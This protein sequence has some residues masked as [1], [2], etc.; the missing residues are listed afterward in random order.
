MTLRVRDN[1]GVFG[2]VF[3]GRVRRHVAG[4]V[5]WWVGGLGYY[6]RRSM[7]GRRPAVKGTGKDTANIRANSQVL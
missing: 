3:P 4:H 1:G 2:G 6:R 5:R 7:L